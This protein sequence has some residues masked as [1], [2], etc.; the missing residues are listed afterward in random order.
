MQDM[1]ED[2]IMA[3]AVFI[4]RCRTNCRRPFIANPKAQW[5][6]TDLEQRLGTTKKGAFGASITQTCRNYD[7]H[8]ATWHIT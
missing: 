8:G 4:I 1:R 2:R 7:I 3:V 5:S 6:P